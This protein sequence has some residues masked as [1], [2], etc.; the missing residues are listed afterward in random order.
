MEERSVGSRRW[1]GMKIEGG[2]WLSESVDE[3]G[4][5]LNNSFA[6]LSR[7]NNRLVSE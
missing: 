3:V 5:K 6:S 2:G 1:L 7:S 4:S